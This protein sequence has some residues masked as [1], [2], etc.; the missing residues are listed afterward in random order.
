MG[1]VKELWKIV[2]EGELQVYIYGQN[3]TYVA[4]VSSDA[5]SEE[6]RTNAALIVAA[7]DLLE[8][9]YA[10]VEVLE[11]NCG[12][13]CEGSCTKG[14]IAAAIT[15]AKRKAPTVNYESQR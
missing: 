12:G 8:A 9:C 1:H 2:D 6:A 11:C 7:P 15:K 10:A 3:G 14:I 13:Q 4:E 5:G